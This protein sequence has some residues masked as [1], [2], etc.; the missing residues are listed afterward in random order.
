LRPKWVKSL[1]DE[2]VSLGLSKAIVKRA[3]LMVTTDSGPR[4]FAAAFGRPVVSIFGP[5]HRQW[6]ITYH[7]RETC[8]QKSVPC[9]PCQQRICPLGHHR[10]MNELSVDEVAVAA[11]RALGLLTER[12]ER[13]A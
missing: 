1:A 3:A 9:G 6:T 2:P 8:V 10:C 5:T 13:V 11:F 4:H 7:P 12:S